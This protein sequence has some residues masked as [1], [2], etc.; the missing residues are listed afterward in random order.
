MQER[1]R[2]VKLVAYPIISVGNKY[3]ALLCSRGPG[4]NLGPDNSYHDEDFHGFPQFLHKNIG[5]VS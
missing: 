1:V 5:R 4:E 3:T 2:N